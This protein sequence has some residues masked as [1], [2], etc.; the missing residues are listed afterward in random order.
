MRIAISGSHGTGKSTL[1]AAFLKRRPHYAH[2]PEAYETLGDDVD[3]SGEKPT[4]EGLEALLRF[5]IATVSAH[6]AGDHVIHERSPADYLAYAGA[7]RRTWGRGEADDS[8]ARFAPLVA[9]S[10]AHLDLIAIVRAS[11]EIAIR[12]GEDD[13]F[14]RRVDRELRRVLLDDAHELF[15][16]VEPVI[17]ELSGAPHKWNTT[18]LGIVDEAAKFGRGD[19]IRPG[20]TP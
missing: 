9:A 20:G 5:S 12:P 6:A 10:L 4:P 19:K 13:R 18:L 1:I 11:A 17:V 15:R 8:I 3:L 16:D 14:R 7:C 2:E